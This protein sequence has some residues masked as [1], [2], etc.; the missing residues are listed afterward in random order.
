MCVASSGKV[1]ALNGTMADVDF[2]GNIVHAEAGLTPV[3]V[4]DY[5]LVHAGLIIQKVSRAE[6]EEIADLFAELED[7]VK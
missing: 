4:G 3:E 1:I 6:H 7:A 2:Q 5:V